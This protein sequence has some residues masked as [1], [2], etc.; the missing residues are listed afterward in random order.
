MIS[1]FL[2][3]I[4]RFARSNLWILAVFLIALIGIWIGEK[5]NILMI[6]LIFLIHC[7]GDIFTMMMGEADQKGQ[8]REARIYQISANFVFLT[9]GLIAFSEK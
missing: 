5:G 6:S 2:N 3:S 9:I 4:L 1:F 7:L 8:I